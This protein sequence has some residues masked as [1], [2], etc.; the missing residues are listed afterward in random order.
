MNFLESQNL[1][2]H[3]NIKISPE[4]K[5]NASHPNEHEIDIDDNDFVDVD[6][7]PQDESSTIVFNPD[8]IRNSTHRKQNTKNFNIRR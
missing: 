5:L 2:V 1:Y 3:H 6:N 4:W 7:N 8:F